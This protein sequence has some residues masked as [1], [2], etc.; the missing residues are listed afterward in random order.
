MKIFRRIF[1][2]KGMEEVIVKLQ[3]DGLLQDD[4]SFFDN[5]DI[6]LE[7][8]FDDFFNVKHKQR[9]AYKKTKEFKDF[10]ALLLGLVN[11]TQNKDE[12]ELER[13]DSDMKKLFRNQTR[14]TLFNLDAVDQNSISDDSS[15]EEEKVNLMD[16]N[17]GKST[18]LDD[19]NEDP[20]GLRVDRILDDFIEQILINHYGELEKIPK[21]YNFKK[22]KR[23]KAQRYLEVKKIEE[24]KAVERA[25]NNFNF[26][27]EQESNKE[28][29]NNS[30]FS[31]SNQDE[32]SGPYKQSRKMTEENLKE[33]E[34]M[35]SQLDERS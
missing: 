19:F 29:L 28:I 7:D 1:W 9:R 14:R 3:L 2:E 15:S 35:V 6:D 16:C 24:D 5:E 8:A 13:A 21:K 30:K 25:L 22:W 18:E 11:K 32:L 27:E 17:N 12:I 33:L 4:V 34:M 20:I 10:G 31:K 23:L 26:L